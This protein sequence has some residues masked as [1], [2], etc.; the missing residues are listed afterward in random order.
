MSVLRSFIG[1]NKLAMSERR[2]T[3]DNGV[4]KIIAEEGLVLYA[5]PDPGAVE[6]AKKNGWPK[7]GDP[8]YGHPWTIGY[9]RLWCIGQRIAEKRLL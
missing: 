1:A 4:K 3:S 2:K 7:P 5:Y 6:A 9:G 8:E